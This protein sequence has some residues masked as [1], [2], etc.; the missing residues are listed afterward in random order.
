LTPSL[1]GARVLATLA[2]LALLGACGTTAPLI[3][4]DRSVNFATY[5]SYAFISDHPM[6]RS[7]ESAT[8]SPLLE[9]RLMR[10]TD[11][12]LQA[13]GYRKV[14][15]PEAADFTVAFT[16]GTREKLNVTSYPEPYRPYVGGWAWGAAYYRGLVAPGNNLA[17]DQYTEGSLAVDIYD[18]AAHKPVWHGVAS[19]R[20]TDAM[21]RNPDEAVNE[22]LNAILAGFPP[23]D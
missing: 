15:D 13:R 3:D 6:L 19:G 4:Y 11:E 18:V 2:L 12:N 23:A 9:A 20:V 10:V 16:V 7:P 17:V 21:R 22:T 1:R 8:A 14:N 5:Q